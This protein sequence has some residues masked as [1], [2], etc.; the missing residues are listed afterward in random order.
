M[1]RGCHYFSRRCIVN[2]FLQSI[3]PMAHFVF[4]GTIALPFY[5]GF[6]AAQA[7]AGGCEYVIHLLG[8]CACP[9]DDDD[10]GE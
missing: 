4:G 9:D 5:L 6:L 1:R 3:G 2:D 10:E 8:L 7:V